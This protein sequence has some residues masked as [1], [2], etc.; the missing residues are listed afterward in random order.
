MFAILQKQINKGVLNSNFIKNV[1]LSLFI[2][3]TDMHHNK[4]V[5]YLEHDFIFQFKVENILK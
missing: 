4:H 1:L 2:N 3:N 5:S